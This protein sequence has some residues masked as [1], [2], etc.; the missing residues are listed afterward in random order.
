MWSRGRLVPPT[1]S[2]RRGHFGGEAGGGESMC[3]FEDGGGSGGI[4]VGAVVDPVA[5][6]G[7]AAAEVVEVRAEEESAC[8]G[9][10][11]G[12][13]ADGVEGLA[14][15][16]L[17]DL[18]DVDGDLRAVGGGEL[19]GGVG[20]EEDD[21][22]RLAGRIV[23]EVDADAGFSADHLRECGEGGCFGD[24][25]DGCSRAAQSG[26]CGEEAFGIGGPGDED[27]G[28]G[29][30]FCAR[31][32]GGGDADEGSGSGR[33]GRGEEEEVRAFVE[34]GVAD[35]ES[36]VA[37]EPGCDEVGGLHVGGHARSGFEAVALELAGDIGGGEFFVARGGAAAGEAS[38][39]RKYS[40][41]VTHSG[42]TVQVC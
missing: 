27:G 20:V 8:G 19:C 40:W 18:V 16:G 37:V 24:E 30:E 13:I 14:G 33:S 31:C 17:G 39:E 9:I 1:R 6:D 22:G 7:A 12:K 15:F 38:L 23:G 34:G 35:L 10:G 25:D 11:S 32:C 41:A 21:G 3:E 2:R 4:I 36:S 5:I 42:L 28:V 29:G 26:D